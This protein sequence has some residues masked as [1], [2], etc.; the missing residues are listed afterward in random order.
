MKSKYATL[1]RNLL[2]SYHAQVTAIDKENY[3]VHS[4]G[5][6]LMELNLQLAKCLEGISATARFNNDID[7]FSELHKITLMAFNGEIP[8]GDNIPMLSSLAS[9]VM[10]EKNSNLK[11]V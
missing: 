2:Q 6:H 10:R 3:S 11:V 9:G 5:I 8:T 7:D 1:I 4:D